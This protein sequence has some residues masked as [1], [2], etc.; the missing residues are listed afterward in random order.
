MK[1]QSLSRQEEKR[2][3]SYVLANLDRFIDNRWPKRFKRGLITVP[4]TFLA[5]IVSFMVI[6]SDTWLTI[7]TSIGGLIVGLTIG[8][9]T[10]QH[11]A[12]AQ[13]QALARCL[14]TGKIESRL[15]ELD[16]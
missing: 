15:R 12:Q 13:W 10:M 14:D 6:Y 7:P 9:V 2:L 4:V 5:V 3:L 11:K 1:V 8:R 16:A